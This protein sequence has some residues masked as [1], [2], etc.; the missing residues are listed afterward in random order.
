M[1]NSLTYLTRRCPRNC[2]YCSLRNAVGV[3]EELTWKEWREAF[4]ILHE[5]GVGFNLI[6]GNETWIL[7]GA[8]IDI[9]KENKVP[10]ALYTTCPE[11]LFS[12]HR[13]SFFDSGI[14]N[15]SCGV[16][17]PPLPEAVQDDSYEKSMSALKGLAWVKR[18]YPHVD[19]QGTITV[20]KKNIKYLPELVHKLSVMGVFV[21]INFIHWN[22][23]GGYDF[24][25]KPEEIHDL[26]FTGRDEHQVRYY[27]NEVMDDEEHLVQN[28]EFLSQ[29][30]KML[31]NMGWHCKGNPYG[32]PTVDSDGHLRCCGYRRGRYS[33]KI[34][35]FDLANKD[36]NCDWK[37]AVYQ[38]AMEC[39]GCAWSYPWMYH[40]WEET[41]PSMGEKVFVKHA[42][43]HI[44]KDKWSKRKIE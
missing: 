5:L 41:N 22:V 30:V 40:F 1:I 44:P 17:Y 35:I 27:L 19:T 3:G 4:R 39:P 10:Y 11:P 43:E 24:F 7:G 36:C 29:D 6:L 9:M 15:L 16:D 14:D 37:E 18:E 34:T 25:P 2:E 26:L 21:G 31:I 13:R 23:D 28:P 33:P 42:G 8:L 38:D 20:H 32:G 12:I